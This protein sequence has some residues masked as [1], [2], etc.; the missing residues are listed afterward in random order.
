[1]TSESARTSTAIIC[2]CSACHVT[3]ERVRANGR[4]ALLPPLVLPTPVEVS[5]H[6]LK[7]KK[8][9]Y[10]GALGRKRTLYPLIV[11]TLGG[12]SA[13]T[14]VFLDG[15]PYSMDCHSQKKKKFSLW[16]LMQETYSLY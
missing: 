1:M 10:Y 5:V 11:H 4:A 16:C 12:G 7:K 14:N 13:G 8:S 15:L 3:V 2:A 9:S 6:I